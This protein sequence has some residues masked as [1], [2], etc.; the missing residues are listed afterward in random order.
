MINQRFTEQDDNFG[1]DNVTLTQYTKDSLNTSFFYEQNQYNL[2]TN[3]KRI[4]DSISTVLIDHPESNL[5]LIGY[6]SDIG[7]SIANQ[8]LSENRV[9]TIK[10]RLLNNGIKE[11]QINTEAKGEIELDNYKN[12]NAQRTQNRRVDISLNSV[13]NII[14]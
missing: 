6:A 12:I 7:N 13:I 8:S 5:N 4:I 1:I 11:N 14:K 10:N 2:S 3:Q 9:K